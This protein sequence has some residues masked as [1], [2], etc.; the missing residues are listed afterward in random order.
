MTWHWQDPHWFYLLLLV[1]ILA[2]IEVWTQRRGKRCLRFPDLAVLSRIPPTWAL[3]LRHVP[4]AMRIAVLVLMTLALARPQTGQTEDEVLTEGI[5][6]LVALDNSGSMAAEDFKPRNRLY[7]A[8]ETVARFIQGRQNDRIGLVAFAEKGYTKCPLTL[9]YGV[10][11]TFLEGVSLAPRTEDGTAIGTGLATCVNRLRASRAKSR[12]IVL[13][14]DGRNNRGAIDP[15]TGAALAQ[16]LG[17]RIYTIGVGTKG[18]APYPVEET[19]FGT[20]YI[21]IPADI[22]EETLRMIADR[23]GGLYFRATD[24]RKLEAIFRRIDKMEK[25][26]EKVKHYTHF[27]ELFPVFL[28]PAAAL[29]LLEVGFSQ[30][31]LRRIP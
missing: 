20:R 18:E 3:R 22:D 28:L 23:T 5:D 4:F 17:I 25:T 10:L 31:R 14:T 16:A 29:L 9:D 19:A 30:T 27:K 13:I 24:A 26:D 2:A 8:K 11:Q 21:Y 1:P 6:I 15:E 12:V 7:V